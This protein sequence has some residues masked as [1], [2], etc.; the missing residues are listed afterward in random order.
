MPVASFSASS[1][2]ARNPSASVPQTPDMPWAAIAPTGSSIPT[3]STS[4]E[5]TTTMMPETNP[6]RMA[7]HGATK[8]HAAVIA[9]SAAIAPFSI[10]ERSGFL[11]TIHEVT[12]A[13]RTPAAA[14]R[15]VFSATYAKKPTPPPT[16]PS[17]ALP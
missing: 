7:A 9:T 11:T 1:G 5:P 8:A 17:A 4:S 12:T 6:I 10:I 15:F 14:A 2:T 16:K 13:P 3:L